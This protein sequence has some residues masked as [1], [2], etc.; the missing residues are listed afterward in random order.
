MTFSLQVVRNTDFL[1]L[2]KKLLIVDFQLSLSEKKALLEIAIIMI[3]EGDESVRK[4]GQ[5]II[6]LYANRYQDY[7]PLYDLALNLGHIPILKSIERINQF[8]ERLNSRFN[9]VFLSSSAEIYKSKDFYLTVEQKSLNDF[10]L[11]KSEQTI[12]VVAPTSYGKSELIIDHCNHKE[13]EN[14]CIIVPTKALIAQT[15]KR[16]ILGISNTEKKIISHPDMYVSGDSEFIAV[17]TQE[18]LLRLLRKDNQLNFQSVFVDEAHNL[19]SNDSRSSL[20]AKTIILLNYR[21]SQTAFKFLTP[22]LIDSNNLNMR[23]TDVDI[24]EFKVDEKLKTERFHY[25]DFRTSGIKRLTFYDQFLNEYIE[26]GETTYGNELTFLSSLSSRKNIIYFNSPPKIEKFAKQLVLSMEP[27]SGDHELDTAVRDIAE[28]LHADYNLLR[29]IKRGFVYHHGSVPEIIRQFVENLFSKNQNIKYILSTSTLLEGVN[30]PAE[31]IFLFEITKGRKK[32][33]PPQ[34]KNLVGRVCRF[35]EIFNIDSG[36]LGLLEP[37]IHV[38][39]TQYMDSRMNIPKFLSGSVKEDKAIKDEALNVLLEE[40]EFDEHN[41]IDKERA[42]Q[43]LE[44]MQ[45]GITG[46]DLPRASTPVGISCYLNNVSEIDILDNEHNMQYQ[47]DL[48][49]DQ[50]I[51]TPE[52]LIKKISEI[53]ITYLSEDN[54][55]YNVLNRLKENAAMA[56]Y[57]MILSWKM[58]GASFSQMIASTVGYWETFEDE[59]LAYVD[60]W[61][62]EVRGGYRPLWTKIKSKNYQERINLAIV[63]IK[64]EQ[65]FLDHSLMKFSDVLYELNK[66]EERTYL[67]V[68]YGTE[69]P[70]TIVLLQNGL[71]ST[72]A[73]LLLTT[74]SSF[75]QINLASNVIK[76]DGNVINEMEN[77]QENTVII[78]E[79]EMHC[80]RLS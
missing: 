7:V 37:E 21:N 75:I 35:S 46:G 2:Y 4:L 6:I 52:S 25:I 20:L 45:E 48:I 40:T 63:R 70:S 30:I 11:N 32:L 69:D 18:R 49:P 56:F 44:N 77:N 26:S 39:G 27:I 3:N 64:E 17:V 12:A 31:K 78:F 65:D 1:G 42:E 76:L 19:L 51:D 72:L 50:Y 15:R 8:K 61:G 22:F 55:S 24:F 60:K 43:F 58:N 13:N 74:Y 67:L 33:S 28:F 71:S 10:F 9:S 80:R 59:Q 68:K 62:D 54:E 53:F 66:V 47:V 73:G 23:Y 57:S 34:F 36:S 14:I 41:L 29:F 79:A 5:R 38:V 16:L